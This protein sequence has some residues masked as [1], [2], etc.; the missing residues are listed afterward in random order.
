MRPSDAVRPA[1]H[2]VQASALDHFG[3]AGAGGSERNNAVFVAVDD[4]RWHINTF[5]V[6]AEVL[7][8]GCDA[9]QAGGG[10]GTG[11]QVPVSLDGLFAH[12]LTQQQV[13]VVEILEEAGEERCRAEGCG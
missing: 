1:L 11:R 12:T 8:P 13:G 9:R 5:Q 4:E 10:G 2:D 6:L 7:V 3:G